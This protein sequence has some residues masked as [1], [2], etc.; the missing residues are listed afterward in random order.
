MQDEGLR[1]IKSDYYSINFNIKH[2]VLIKNNNYL[3]D[4]AIKEL[5]S[6]INI[7]LTIF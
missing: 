2:V 6:L 5:H 1:V 4:N 7:Y 3:K